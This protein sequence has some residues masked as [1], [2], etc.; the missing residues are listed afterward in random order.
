M[1]KVKR[2]LKKFGY[3]QP[4]KVNTVSPL[5]ENVL[6]D[7]RESIKDGTID[8]SKVNDAPMFR[9][10]IKLNRFTNPGLSPVED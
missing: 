4:S 8:A 7:L 6:N 5:R 10:D 9:T 1:S 2:K 3:Y